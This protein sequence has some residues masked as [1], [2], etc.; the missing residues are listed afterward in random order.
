[1]SGTAPAVRSTRQ[2]AA[3]SALLDDRE[4]FRS[5]QEL[6]D[7]LRRRGDGIGLTTVYRTLQ[8]TMQ[9]YK[10]EQGLLVCWGGFNKVVLAEAK[11]GHFTVRLWD[12]R[13]VVEAIYRTYEHLPAEI[14]ADLPLKRV[15]MLVAEDTDV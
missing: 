1:M 11:Q 9:T 10:A 5:A 13:D 2:R 4:E 15:W 6:H 12:S 8:G 7:E 14:Q 3:I